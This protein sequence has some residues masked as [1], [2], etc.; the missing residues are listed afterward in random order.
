MTGVCV[1]CG[2]LVLDRDRCPRDGGPALPWRAVAKACGVTTLRG[3]L[4]LPPARR[5][6]GLTS[7][8]SRRVP[9]ILLDDFSEGVVAR[10]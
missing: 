8:R 2:W 4:N 5:V 9:R 7:S 10:R 1:R 6:L 3:L